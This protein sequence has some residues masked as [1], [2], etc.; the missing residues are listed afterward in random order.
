MKKVVPP[1]HVNP[2]SMERWKTLMAGWKQPSPPVEEEEEAPPP[3]VANKA[4]WSYAG[5]M[6]GTDLRQSRM[7]RR[8]SLLPE[9]VEAAMNLREK[10]LVFLRDERMQLLLRVNRLEGSLRRNMAEIDVELG[11]EWRP[12]SP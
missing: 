12:S 4:H 1:V 5:R 6:D 9:V 11:K 7:D 10:R 3:P 8:G 2:N